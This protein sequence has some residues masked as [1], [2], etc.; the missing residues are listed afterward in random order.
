MSPDKDPVNDAAL[1]L[2]LPVR[3]PV[4]EFAGFEK[5]YAFAYVPAANPDVV[6]PVNPAPL[7]LNDAALIVPLA[8]MLPVTSSFDAG[9][10]L[11]MPTLPLAASR[12]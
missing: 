5:V 7:S 6:T 1:P 10:V 2:A 12:R 4:K 3:F 11:P 9:L 8:L